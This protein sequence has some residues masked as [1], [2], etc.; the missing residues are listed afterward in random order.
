MTERSPARPRLQR[1]YLALEPRM[2]FDA[3]AVATAT[4]VAAASETQSASPAADKTADNSA[5]S[6]AHENSSTS[7]NDQAS[8]T[9]SQRTTALATDNGAHLSL[10]ALTSLETLSTISGLSN[11]AHTELSS[12]GTTL[13]AASR[14]GELAIF[15]RDTETGALTLS[16]TLTAS[17]TQLTLII[18]LKISPDGETLLMSGANGRSYSDT[19]AVFNRDPATGSL[20]FLESHY[21]LTIE[22]LEISDDG[23]SVYAVDSGNE[24]IYVF[25]RDTTSG[26]LTRLNLVENTSWNPPYMFAIS[27]MESRGDYVFVTT[28]TFSPPHTLIAYQRDAD[29]NLG[30]PFYIRD[31]Q[32]DSAGNT[33]SLKSPSQINAS[34]DGQTLYVTTSEGI[35][36]F[37]VEN[38]SFVVQNSISQA[39]ITSTAL[40]SNGSTLYATLSDGTINR[41]SATTSG[42]MLLNSTA[43]GQSDAS[44]IQVSAD[45]G[46]IVTGS[47]ISVLQEASTR[48]LEGTAPQKLSD[49]LVS[50][51]TLDALDN[52]NGDYNGASFSVTPQR[53]DNAEDTLSFI[54]TSSLTLSS[55]GSQILNNGTAIANLTVN[56][57]SLSITFTGQV[58]TALANQVLQQIG[59]S[60]ISSDAGSLAVMV[61]AFDNGQGA[62]TSLNVEVRLV[63]VN[64]APTLT[65]TA[66][67]PRYS[68]QGNPVAVFQDTVI[69]T[70][71]RAQSVSGLALSVTGIQDGANEVLVVDGTRIALTQGNTGITRSGLSYEVSVSGTTASV[72][73]SGGNLNVANAQTLVNGI[74]YYNDSTTIT[75]VDRV[76][77]LT[78]IRDNGTTANGGIDSTALNLTSTVTMRD[79]SAPLLSDVPTNQAYTEKAA[80]ISLLADTGFNDVE[81]DSDGDYRDASIRIVRSE[82]AN[83]ADIFGFQD[84]NGFT[85]SADGKQVLKDGDVIASF[86]LV[87]GALV[88]TFTSSQPVSA[89]DANLVIKQITYANE[90]S[91]PGSQISLNLS[92]NDGDGLTSSVHTIL[93]AVTEINDA[94]EL[95]ATALDPTLS[96]GNNTA[97]FS[98][99]QISTVEQGQSII[100]LRLEISGLSDG[101]QERLNING[102]LVEL[103][104]GTQTVGDYTYTVSLSAGTATLI[105]TPANGIDTEAAQTLIDGIRYSNASLAPT[106]GSRTVTLV[107]I[108]DSGG[109]LDGG[110][111]V[112]D[113]NIA[114]TVDVTA[115]TAPGIS[116]PNPG[117]VLTSP[118]ITDPTQPTHLTPGSVDSSPSAMA[119]SSDGKF[120]Y[121]VTGKTLT[122]HARTSDGLVEQGSFSDDQYF[123]DRDVFLEG[124]DRVF[125]VTLSAD[126]RFLYVAGFEATSETGELS[127]ITLYQRDI[128]TGALS[129]VGIAASND[130][131]S[132]YFGQMVVSAD[133]RSLYAVSND[134]ANSGITTFTINAQGGL[135]QSGHLSDG[136]GQS[137]DVVI[138][139]DGRSVYVSNSWDNAIAI[140]NR[141]TTTGALSYAGSLTALGNG[142]NLSSIGGLALSSAGDF[143]YVSDKNSNS[144]RIFSRSVD[145]SLTLSGTVRDGLRSVYSLADITLSADGSALYLAHEGNDPSLLVYSRD[146]TTGALTFTR[147][148]TSSMGFNSL[149]S[150][151]DGSLYALGSEWSGADVVILSSPT[152]APHFT[153][154]GDA[155]L[156][157]PNGLVS[158]AE[159][160][161]LN[162]GAGNYNGA[163][164]TLARQEGAS[165]EDR[166][167]LQPSATL[168]LSS[169]GSQILL[170][171]TA[172]A[173]FS[174]TEGR[175]TIAFI[176]DV[177]QAQAQ[178]VLQHLTY[179]NSAATPPA[180]VELVASINDGLL[181]SNSA[182]FTVAITATSTPVIT[183]PVVTPPVVEP[184]VVTPPVVV[185]PVVTPPDAGGGTVI[186]PP[187]TD[188]DTGSSTP[189]TNVTEPVIVAAQ[190]APLMGLR[191]SGFNEVRQ[192]E[193]SLPPGISP[194]GLPAEINSTLNTILPDATGLESSQRSVTEQLLGSSNILSDTLASSQSARPG[195]TWQMQVAA[196]GN[197]NS[198]MQL[199]PSLLASTQ[200]SPQLR[201][202]NG[203]PLPSWARFDPRSGKLIVDNRQLAAAQR[204]NLVL[205]TRDRSGQEQ[206]TP[207]QIETGERP[208]GAAT[209]QAPANTPPAPAAEQALRAQ[210]QD[211]APSLNL[212]HQAQS[213]LENLLS[214]VGN[215]SNETVANAATQDDQRVA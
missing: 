143:L 164:L 15:T 156:L 109:T 59:Y 201:M 30:S 21:I 142:Q 131:S 115:N 124:M 202:S 39:N 68:A 130:T 114:S 148:Y 117:T 157:A 116:N 173:T 31:G 50:D 104:N 113:L 175:L 106:L 184:P 65:T 10:D 165:T 92:I 62:S 33:V 139:S 45:G 94:P 81:L 29:G 74:G 5:T 24:G 93:I 166:F 134:S 162:D 152:I 71:E 84:G 70:G 110:T 40:S 140:F 196:N 122:I 83:A 190:S 135:S 138:S 20:V 63:D 207:V 159:L 167:G 107:S 212:A 17:D 9:T 103:V 19:L 60:N 169:D 133:G 176:E 195:E 174:Q 25:S 183:P 76:V 77:G 52:G 182:S 129:Y 85:L 99:T 205:I 78:L 123:S 14:T 32:R 163:T 155:V 144:I 72:S 189:T 209:Q 121:I 82:G 132:S 211:S 61:L 4:E 80:A 34:P 43:G 87:D 73:L 111:D 27:A 198:E 101:S 168:G 204:L 18:D 8:A 208:Q 213:L 57:S 120:V 46:V 154:G 58:S 112:S 66:T 79:N 199:P 147:A 118:N 171:G 22:T 91:D 160:D 16:N 191:P 102:T 38:Q 56:G 151:T 49:A 44:A 214:I 13:Y 200:S 126:G 97:L 86:S 194:L 1:L 188:V 145:G 28:Q 203:L 187:P 119:T 141:D 26:S 35:V 36:T 210:L 137:S 51:S 206:R 12:D 23:K 96:F 89:A 90:N 100:D 172:I 128:T 127:T 3:A 11:I 146:A 48:Y 161:A 37:R 55:D 181:T 64:N 47:G 180:Q 53:G 192:T 88:L 2:M 150:A 186:T 149:V 95:S 193:T 153:Q 54:P 69:N 67:D 177:S 125:S 179:L 6:V 75:G 197:A 136:I 215:E 105:I 170:N 42:L 108:Q 185:P 7:D 41:Y 98:D 158:D 178:S